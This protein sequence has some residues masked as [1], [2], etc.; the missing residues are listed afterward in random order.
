MSVPPCRSSLQVYSSKF[1]SI[2]SWVHSEMGFCRQCQHRPSSNAGKKVKFCRIFYNTLYRYSRCTVNALKRAYQRLFGKVRW[3]KTMLQTSQLLSLSSWFLIRT[4]IFVSPW[5][6]IYQTN[7]YV[8]SKL[9]SKKK[10]LL[11][12]S[13]IYI[14]YNAHI[15]Y[16]TGRYHLYISFKIMIRIKSRK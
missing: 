15:M 1:C 2:I 11:V 3:I 8:V 13:F 9:Q 5:R 12:H 4:V 10:R 7:P 16:N 14:T 6:I